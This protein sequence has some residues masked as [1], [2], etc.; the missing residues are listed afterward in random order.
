MVIVVWTL[1]GFVWGALTV[2]WVL[3]KLASGDRA[4]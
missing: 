1:A 2:L 4:W 3:G